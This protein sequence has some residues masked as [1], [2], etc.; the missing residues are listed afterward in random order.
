MWKNY[1]VVIHG[2]SQTNYSAF[3]PDFP[4]LTIQADTI[5]EI[6]D[7]VQEAVEVYLDEGE[8]LPPP[9]DIDQV[10]QTHPYAK[11]GIIVMGTVSG[12]F[13]DKLERKTI[14]ARTSEWASIDAAAKTA[15][16]TRSAFLVRTALER[17]RELGI[18]A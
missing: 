12:A 10:M 15:K 18:P 4:G 17:A 13:R 3:L 2:D 11:G 9:S 14:S 5:G 7:D 1:P 16:S 8:E 6:L